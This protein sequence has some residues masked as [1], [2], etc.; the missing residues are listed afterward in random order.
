MIIFCILYQAQFK[1]H[2]FALID[3]ET[4]IYAFIDKFFV[5]QYNIPL[6]SLIY[7]WRLWGFNDQTAFIDDI[8]HVTKIIMIIKDYIKRLFLYVTE[9][10]QYLIVMSLP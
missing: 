6:H 10:N 7:L 4:L 9:L 5:Q 3:S 2:V 8:T 1:I